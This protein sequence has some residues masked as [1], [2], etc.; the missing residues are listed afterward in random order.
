MLSLM[1]FQADYV[2]RMMDLGE[3]DAAARIPEIRR[4]LE[5]TG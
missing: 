4:F 5:Q 2:N 3:E 1:M